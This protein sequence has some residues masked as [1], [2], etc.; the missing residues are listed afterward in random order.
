MDPLRSRAAS[1]TG[2]LSLFTGDI[3]FGEDSSQVRTRNG[4]RVM[5]SLR[6]LIVTI[7]R[8]TGHASIAAALR[9]HARRPGR[10]LQ[11]IVALEPGQRRATRSRRCSAARKR[12][13]SPPAG[14][15][16]P[17]RKRPGQLGLIECRPAQDDHVRMVN[18]RSASVPYKTMTR[19][20]RIGA[21]AGY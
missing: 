3:T 9:Y 20:A 18:L 15:L 6:N 4:P 7:L 8:L 10:P 16:V 11:S 14:V 1:I 5:A 19:H 12:N 21:N 13:L 17:D 2:P